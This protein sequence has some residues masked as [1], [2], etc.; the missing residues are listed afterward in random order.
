MS[1]FLVKPRRPL[2]CKVFGLPELILTMFHGLALMSVL[3][4]PA[5]ASTIGVSVSTSAPSVGETFVVDISIFGLT[6]ASGDSLSAFDFDIV[7]D[8]GQ[9]KLTDYG[10]D[11]P[12][13]GNQ[14]DLAEVG[15]LAFV[16][17][18]LDLGGGLLDVYG[19]SGNSDTVLDTDQATAFRF[20]TLSFQALAPT[21][22]TAIY[23]DLNDPS[24][25]VLDSGF[26]DLAYS[27]SSSGATV[28]VSDQRNNVPAPAPI[29]LITA[30]MLL[31]GWF[32]RVSTTEGKV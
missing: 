8:D 7:Y 10:F 14:L 23:I 25:M 9:L 18:V 4:L 3:A 28:A 2:R 6:S 30:G 27:F 5:H 16:G 17:E 26:G 13:L 15:K 32:R 1:D 21:S 24:L 11:D 22:S 19:L 12:A 29:L 31:I 20:L